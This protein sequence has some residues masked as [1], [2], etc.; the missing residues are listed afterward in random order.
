VARS[1]GNSAEILVREFGAAV[2][3]FDDFLRR[4]FCPLRLDAPR[5]AEHALQA[6]RRSGDSEEKER[7]HGGS[8]RLSRNKTAVRHEC[9]YTFKLTGG[10]GAQRNLRPV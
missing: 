9:T 1:Q 6:S 2:E 7:D 8:H 5:G 10:D 3:N 4:D